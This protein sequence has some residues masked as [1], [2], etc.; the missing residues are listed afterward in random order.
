MWRRS[1]MWWIS[2][3]AGLIPM[4]MASG[5]AGQ[6]G[7]RHALSPVERWKRFSAAAGLE[8]PD[9]EIEVIAAPLDRLTA[10]ARKALEPDLGL[11]EPVLCFR[12]LRGQP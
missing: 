12:I 9:A 2:L 10:A 11:T 1:F 6:T 5:E 4:A 8:I 3:A 7:V